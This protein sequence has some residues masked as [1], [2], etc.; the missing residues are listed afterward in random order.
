MPANISAHFGK[1]SCPQGT[2]KTGSGDSTFSIIS[3][4]GTV[5][6]LGTAT[7][8]YVRGIH[9]EP[10]A[11]SL[12]CNACNIFQEVSPLSPLSPNTI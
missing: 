3:T 2:A 5:G 6:A 12:W 9:T 8:A 11:T 7:S 1:G 4:A 10:P